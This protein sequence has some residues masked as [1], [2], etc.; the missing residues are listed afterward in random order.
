M[1]SNISGL[2][3]T[4]SILFGRA[5][6][7]ATTMSVANQDHKRFFWMAVLIVNIAFFAVKFE[8]LST[9]NYQFN[10]AE[11]EL[12]GAEQGSRVIT[13]GLSIVSLGFFGAWAFFKAMKISPPMNSI[14]F[15]L[16]YAFLAWT[17]I[18]ILWSDEPKTTFLR[19]I[20][21]ASCIIGG[22]GI[23]RRMRTGDL[24]K[25]TLYVSA[26][27][28]LF[29]AFGEMAF[30]AFRPWASGY[31]F[32]G[33]VHP[34]AQGQYCSMACLAA[35]ALIGEWSVKR[36]MMFFVPGFILLVLTGSRTSCA[37]TLLSMLLYWSFFMQARTRWLVSIGLAFLVCFGMLMKPSGDSGGGGGGEA[38]G[39]SR[40]MSAGEDVTSFTGRLPL[41]QELMSYVWEKPVTGF[42]YGAF[43]TVQH[44][45]ELFDRVYWI[46]PSAH[47]AFLEAILQIGFVGFFL[48]VWVSF[49]AWYRSWVCFR[50]T[51][52]PEYAFIFALFLLCFI[53][54]VFES[55][56]LCPALISFI[57]GLGVIRVA[58]DVRRRGAPPR[59]ALRRQPL[60]TP[61]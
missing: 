48:M 59:A 27:Y 28:M 37:A 12:E 61:R 54:C 9:F 23:G 55:L 46:P 51:H 53:G 34:N 47:N 43:F 3:P 6:P 21:M 58:A 25:L 44:K 4:G 41:W 49:Y 5:R 29:G 40:L 52:E 36:C 13:R 11:V 7:R 17:I 16:S 15:P 35:I 22:I 24:M 30:G 60:L 32:A 14:L 31:R 26:A 1:S 50:L 39:G 33:G 56:L 42:G 20:Q 19:W 2:N 38:G 45:E 57:C 10:S 8:V 18:S